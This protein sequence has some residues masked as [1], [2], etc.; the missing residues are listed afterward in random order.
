MPKINISIDS[1]FADYLHDLYRYTWEAAH[2]PAPP[3]Q[4]KMYEH[5]LLSVRKAKRRTQRAVD[6]RQQTARKNKIVRGA[7]H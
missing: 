5:F 6:L 4:E 3:D 1:E 7:N 2:T